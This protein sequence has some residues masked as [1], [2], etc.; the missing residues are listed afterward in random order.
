MRRFSRQFQSCFDEIRD[1]LLIV[2]GD[3]AI[4]EANPAARSALDV[5]EHERIT[6]VAWADRRVVFDG[7]SIMPLLKGPSDVVGHRLNDGE[8]NETDIV[9]DIIDLSAKKS[10]SN[11]KLIHVKDYSAYTNYERWKD[12]VLSMVAHEI[13]NPLAAM[14]NS[15]S[16]LVSHAAGAMT[17]GQRGLLDVSLR[18]ID[19]LTRLLDNVL[20][21]S[22]IGSGS[23]IP[24]PRW[25]S[26]R[27][28]AAEVV[29]TF[30]TLF[31][32]Q[33]RRLDY[34]I[35]EDPG[36]VYVDGPK[37]EQILVNLLTN[38]VKFTQEGGEITVE[39]EPAGLEVLDDDLRILPWAEVADLKFVRFTVGDT[40]IGMTEDV[41]SHLFTRYY[42]EKGRGRSKGSHL[43][44][45]ISKALAEVQ[46]GSLEFESELGVG[47]R[48]SVALPADE[49]T[50]TVLGCV[51]SVGRVLARMSGLRRGVVCRVYRKDRYL[52][53]DHVIEDSGSRAVVNPTIGE[54][55]SGDDY[56]WTLS[57]QVAVSLA[58]E[59]PDAQGSYARDDRTQTSPS[60]PSGYAV[61]SKRLSS[62]EARVARVLAFAFKNG[63][64]GKK[65]DTGQMAW[66]DT[67]KSR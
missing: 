48:A 67:D 25:V 41:L 19:R 51:K 21:V 30:K 58:A 6:E 31:N 54:E 8:G 14:K 27:D 24:E 37:L 5:G 44:L 16:G 28:F 61:S 66:T 64:A 47:T 29:G 62:H 33:R 55:R 46:N 3:G 34:A 57:D 23:Y 63:D 52:P 45:S 12:E 10:G 65:S 26:A 7:R 59:E 50:F 15:M 20:D 42:E 9:V 56:L 11:L 60:R 35:S 36:L 18:S 40:G 32:V 39:V 43:G 22:R 1:P 53:W 17:D 4:R 38:A 13:K 49:A 2:D